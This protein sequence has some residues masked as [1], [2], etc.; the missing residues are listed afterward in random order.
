MG[1]FLS[2]KLGFYYNCIKTTKLP[3]VQCRLPPLCM[4]VNVHMHCVKYV[5][6]PALK[7]CNVV[8]AQ[9]QFCFQI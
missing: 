6:H 8:M 2:L 7:S 1:L 4:Y 9:Y 3:G 5:K